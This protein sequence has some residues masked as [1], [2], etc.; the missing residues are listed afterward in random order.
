[1][2]KTLPPTADQGRLSDEDTAL[3]LEV[4]E[5]LKGVEVTIDL[6]AH[7]TRDL[8]NQAWRKVMGRL[9]ELPR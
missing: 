2:T 6:L 9:S 1:M 8:D 7:A 4:A 3:L 5:K